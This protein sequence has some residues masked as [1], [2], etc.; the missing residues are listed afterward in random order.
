VP[1]EVDPLTDNSRVAD[2]CSFAVSRAYPSPIRVRN[3]LVSRTC[4]STKQVSF[5]L[6]GSETSNCRHCHASALSARRI[7]IFSFFLNEFVLTLGPSSTKSDECRFRRSQIGFPNPQQL[8]GRPECNEQRDRSARTAQ[9][10]SS[11]IT[12]ESPGKDTWPTEAFPGPA[13]PAC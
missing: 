9:R 5:A 11:V 8:F 2:N 10:A 4:D 13:N 7:S 3:V 6:T 1:T 12:G